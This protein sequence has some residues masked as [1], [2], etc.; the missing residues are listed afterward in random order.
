VTSDVDHRNVGEPHRERE[1]DFGVAEVRSSN[2]GLGDERAD[3]QTGSHAGEA[4]EKSFEGDLVGG[5]ERR[6]PGQR[7]RFSFEAALLD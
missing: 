2:G 3:E 7:R 5:F 1:E 4:K 6:E